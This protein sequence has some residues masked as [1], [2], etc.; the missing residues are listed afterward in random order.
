MGKKTRLREIAITRIIVP[1]SEDLKGSVVKYKMYRVFVKPN[2]KYIQKY[3]ANL[4]DARKYLRYWSV[5]LNKSYKQL[6]NV[7]SEVLAA[8]ERNWIYL[9][10]QEYQ[11]LHDYMSNAQEK[12]RMIYTR[13]WHGDYSILVFNWLHIAI[14]EITSAIRLLVSFLRKANRLDNQFVQKSLILKLQVIQN[15]LK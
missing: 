2:G 9:L 7:Y 6:V 11:L 14:D 3:F 8:I 5:K 4:K 13:Q 10:D 15:D 1:N 12:I